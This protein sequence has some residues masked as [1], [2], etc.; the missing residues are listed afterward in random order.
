M[1][2]VYLRSQNNTHSEELLGFALSINS[3][4]YYDG[5]NCVFE[6]NGKQRIQLKMTLEGFQ[7]DLQDLLVCVE[8]FNQD[9]IM[10]S[11]LQL[12]ELYALGR[13]VHIAEILLLSSLR[14]DDRLLQMLNAYFSSFNPE[15]IETARMYLW[16]DGNAML[17]AEALYL[18][19]NTFNYRMKKF[20]EKSSIQLNQ[21]AQAHFFQIWLNLQNK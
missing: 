16:A 21:Q 14:K 8:G 15:L 19:R 3:E 6:V 18:H 12:A 11:T 13:F 1:G 5:N 17:A 7:A 2:L 20:S 9:A 4:A 10:S